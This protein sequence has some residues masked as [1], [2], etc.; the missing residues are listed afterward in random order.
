MA[1]LTYTD[2]QTRVMNKLR[3]PTSNT[4]EAT[5]VAAMINEVYR[6]IAAKQDWWWLVKRTVINT[7]DDVSTGTVS[8]TNN[9]TA[10]TFSSAPATSVAGFVL[11]VPGN[12]LDSGAVYRIATHTAAATA[13]TLDAAY[14]G[15]T[16]TAIAYNV[17]RDQYDLPSDF[18]KP[19]WIKRFGYPYPLENIGPEEM[20]GIKLYSTAAGKPEI[21]TVDDFSTT[22]DPTTVRQLIVHPYPDAIFR[23]EAKYKQTLNTEL[24][25][26]TRPLIPDDY[27]NVLIYGALGEGFPVFLND[28][29]RGLYFQGLFVDTLNLMSAA[30][31][32]RTGDNPQIVPHD[33]YRQYYETRRHV[34]PATADLGSYFDRWVRRR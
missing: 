27:V 13:A 9:S 11:L 18:G 17:Y 7:S 23:L 1:T 28:L 6:T 10:I 14:T 21:Y 25:G 8:V 3:I 5:K 16:N 4:T 30:Q 34:D 31:K 15:A 26:T 33:T 32:E 20:A 19:L 12:T 2:I 24:S 22:G 29:E